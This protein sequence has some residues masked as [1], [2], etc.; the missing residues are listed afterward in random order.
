MI[1]RKEWKEFRDVGLLFVIN[2]FLHL[3]GQ[4]IVFRFSEKNEVI[5]VYPAR[6]KF[7]G[8][9]Q[10]STSEGYEKITKYLKENIKELDEEVNIKTTHED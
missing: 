8:F 10:K 7:R 3:F 1:K 4:A 9:D 6:V 2:Q 5:E